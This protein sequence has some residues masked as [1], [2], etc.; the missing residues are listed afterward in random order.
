MGLFKDF[1]DT[2]ESPRM[3]INKVEVP[4]V[5]KET[6]EYTEILIGQLRVIWVGPCTNGIVHSTLRFI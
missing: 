6:Y 1:W 2:P 3:H 5:G 4:W